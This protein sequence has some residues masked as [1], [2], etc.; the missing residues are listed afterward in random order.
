MTGNV[1][2][3]KGTGG[4]TA[5]PSKKLY[6]GVPYGPND[7]HYSCAINNYNDERNVRYCELVGLKDLDQVI[8]LIVP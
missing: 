7:F 4:S 5:E 3:A 1:E 6:P 2:N 8:L